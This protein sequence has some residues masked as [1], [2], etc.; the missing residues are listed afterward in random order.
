MY[1]HNSTLWTPKG[2][3]KPKKTPEED[4]FK[5]MTLIDLS[6]LALMQNSNDFKKN[7]ENKNFPRAGKAAEKV[8][9]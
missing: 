1:T 9:Y 6:F 8:N 3:I 7:I 5:A 4:R 2:V